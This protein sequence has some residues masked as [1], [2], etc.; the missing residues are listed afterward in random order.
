L[1][2]RVRTITATLDDVERG[3]RQ[4]QRPRRHQALPAP[5]PAALAAAVTVLE[6]RAGLRPPHQLE[7]LSHYTLWPAWAHL[8]QRPA[9]RPVPIVPRPLSVTLREVAPGLVDATVVI[10]FCGRPHALGLRLDG[11]PGFWQLLELDYPAELEAPDLHSADR[12]RS[13]VLRR[14][15]DSLTPDPRE[16][17]G[18]RQALPDPSCRTAGRDPRLEVDLSE[19]LGIDLG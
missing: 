1:G 8:A 11:A 13:G 7:R 3:W 19:S 5:A 15:R 2:Q 10:D 16:H 12:P 17:A 6:V 18:H 14:E 9:D 4:I